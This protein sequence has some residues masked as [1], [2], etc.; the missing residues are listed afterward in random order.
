MAAM[1]LRDTE[2]EEDPEDPKDIPDAEGRLAKLEITE[3]RA[4]LEREE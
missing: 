2:E 1:D 3:R 4:K